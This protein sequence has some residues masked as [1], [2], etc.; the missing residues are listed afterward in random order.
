MKI[1]VTGA[2][3]FIGFHL[4]RRLIEQ[5]NEIIGID[6]LNDYYPVSLKYARL[7]ECGIDENKIIQGHV[8]ESSKYAKYRF[9]RMD[10][11]DKESIQNI[12]AIERF[13]IIVNLAAQAGVR[14]SIENPYT[15]VRSNIIGFLNLLEAARLNQVKHFVYA[16]SSSVY[17]GNIT[18]PFSEN[19]RVDNPVS[20]YAATKK[21]DELMAHVYSKLYNLPTTG[22]RFFTVY[23]PWGRPDMAPMLFTHAI[24]TGEPIKVFNNGNLSR[25]FTYIDDIIEGVIR[26]IDNIPIVSVPAEIYNIGCGHPVQLMDFIHTLENTLGKKAQ[27]IMLPMQ[28]GDVY[29]TYA[30]TSKLE[31]AIGY[32]AKIELKQG[33]EIFVAWYKSFCS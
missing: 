16:S 11:E 3:G 7:R 24:L 2:A 6:N 12:F 10:I 29:T 17:G 20:I 26:V 8:V 28:K 13:D 23:G 19:D 31:Q 22:L 18:V 1:L 4:V 21:S 33:I 25:D 27:M 15:Y 32:K 30:N 5:G 14:Y 9:I